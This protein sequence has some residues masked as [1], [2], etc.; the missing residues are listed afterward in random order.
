MNNSTILPEKIPQFNGSLVLTVNQDSLVQ[1]IDSYI[2]CNTD[3]FSRTFIQ[4]MIEKGDVKINGLIVHKPSTIVKSGDV[5]QV[6]VE[7]Q[8]VPCVEDVRKATEKIEI[9]YEHEHFFIINKPAG[10]LVHRPHKNSNEVTVVDWLL[11]HNLV[12]HTVGDQ[13]RPGIVHRLDKNTSGLMIIART[14]YGHAYI[15]KLFQERLI[16]KT[17]T[18]IVQGVVPFQGSIDLYIGRDPIT[19]SRMATS[20]VKSDH[21]FRSSLTHFKAIAINQGVSLVQVFPVTGRTHQIRVHFK[22][23]G[24][25][26]LGDALYNVSDSLLARHALHASLLSFTFNNQSISMTSALPFDLQQVC[27][28]YNFNIDECN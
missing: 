28:Y 22:A 1:R 24:H 14:V 20:R 2:S 27:A 7:Q 5:V 3:L 21:T 19:K 10:I 25:P 12:G 13:A 26:L 23:I 17:Y 16:K 6:H 18:A 9:V 4:K 11:A 8:F 15:A